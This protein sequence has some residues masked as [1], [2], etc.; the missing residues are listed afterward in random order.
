MRHLEEF[1]LLA[2]IIV[3]Y[4]I[5]TYFA[6]L[7]LVPTL[8]GRAAFTVAIAM[9][10]VALGLIVTRQD[11]GRLMFLWGAGPVILMAAGI[12]FWISWLI[13]RIVGLN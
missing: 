1:T 6:V 11:E 12:A 13:G 10:I 2:L 7:A 9:T 8:A 4:W 3:L 5:S